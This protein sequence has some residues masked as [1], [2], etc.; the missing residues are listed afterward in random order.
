MKFVETPLKDVYLLEPRVFGDSRGFFLETWNAET[1]REAGFDLTFMQD[2]HSRS[3]GGIL[4][5]MGRTRPAAVFN[6][7]GYYVLALPLAGYLAF[8]RGLGI[9]G[10]DYM[11]PAGQDDP[12]RLLAGDR[13]V[14]QIEAAADIPYVDLFSLWFDR[15]NY[16]QT[17]PA[18]QLEKMLW[19]EADR[20]G[21][22]L[23]AVTQEKFEVQRETVKNERGQRVDARMLEEADNLNDLIDSL[24]E[25]SRLQAGTFKLEMSDDVFLPAL[26]R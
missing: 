25:V 1:F 7:V 19:L 18:N 26:A 23:D 16:F 20:M 6:L 22:L 21:F 2:N 17:V 15:T 14:A 10:V 9:V 24:L 5:G 3:A 4:R 8:G 12:N 13:A 11:G